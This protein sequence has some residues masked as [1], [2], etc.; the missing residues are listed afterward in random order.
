MET[1]TRGLLMKGL[2]ERELTGRGQHISM[3]SDVDGGYREL[4][5]L[6]WLDRNRR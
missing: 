6:V 5:A 1:V 2:S 3:V 4:L